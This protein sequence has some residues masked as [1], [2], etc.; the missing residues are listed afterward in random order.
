MAETNG[1]GKVHWQVVAWVLGVV[2]SALMTYNTTASSYDRR[3]SVLED[4]YRRVTQDMAEIKADVKFLIQR[5]YM[6]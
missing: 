4:Q 5:S 2:V 1:T 6:P 3:L